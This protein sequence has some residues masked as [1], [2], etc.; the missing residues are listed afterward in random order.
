MRTFVTGSHEGKR[1]ASLRNAMQSHNQCPHFWFA[2]VLKFVDAN[3]DCLMPVSRS[4][5]DCEEELLSPCTEIEEDPFKC[6]SATLDAKLGRNNF[7]VGE[8]ATARGTFAWDHPVSQ[9]GARSWRIGFTD[10]PGRR[11]RVAGKVV[12]LIQD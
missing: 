8:S 7:E 1:Q 10:E 3:R 9:N 12:V 6:S 2:E 4:L 5:S 11:I